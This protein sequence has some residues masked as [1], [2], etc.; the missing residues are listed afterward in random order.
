M[1]CV[2]CHSSENEFP[3]RFTFHEF[4]GWCRKCIHDEIN[5]KFKFVQDRGAFRDLKLLM[6][7]FEAGH[8]GKEE[9]EREKK[10]LFEI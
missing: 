9:F 7:R 4:D 10:K 3:D 1:T 5:L 6:I 2:N 8:I